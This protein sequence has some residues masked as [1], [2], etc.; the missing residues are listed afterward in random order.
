MWRKR[1]V[2]SI[3]MLLN[4]KCLDMDM[5]VLHNEFALSLFTCNAD[6]L[7]FQICILQ[8]ISGWLF[9]R[10]REQWGNRDKVY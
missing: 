9:E 6:K 5:L 4:S 8:Y 2:V 1:E 10:N 7:E 3:Q